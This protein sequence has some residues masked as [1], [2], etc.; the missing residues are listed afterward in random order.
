MRASKRLDH[1]EVGVLTKIAGRA[2]QF[3]KRPQRLRTYD[4]RFSQSILQLLPVANNDEFPGLLKTLMLGIH[5]AFVA[6]SSSC[7]TLYSRHA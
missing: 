7:V 3:S 5:F 4:Q 1:G 2:R 6:S